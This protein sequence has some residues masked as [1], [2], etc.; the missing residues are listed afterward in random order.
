MKFLY[1]VLLWIIPVS[2]LK[3][4]YNA[5]DFRLKTKNHREFILQAF[6]IACSRDNWLIVA[7][8]TSS[9]YTYNYG[10]FPRNIL[11][12][13]A[14]ASHIHVTIDCFEEKVMRIQLNCTSNDNNDDKK[15]S[16]N[17]ALLDG[18]SSNEKQFLEMINT[19]LFPDEHN[20]SNNSVFINV[21]TCGTCFTISH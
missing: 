2:C 20:W 14:E 1:L 17:F 8:S 4:D 5:E 10:F 6:A 15:Y 7:S 18:V 11:D 13:D 16:F 3:T 9:T 12:I 19:D 21:G